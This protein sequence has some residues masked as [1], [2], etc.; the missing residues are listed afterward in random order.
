MPGEES[1]KEV[2][3]TSLE[4]FSAKEIE[5]N[6]RRFSFIHMHISVRARRY[7]ERYRWILQPE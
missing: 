2:E 4:P 1:A 6:A 7:S 3:I 5:V